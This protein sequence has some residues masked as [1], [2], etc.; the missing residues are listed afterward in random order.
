MVCFWALLSQ[1]KDR[2]KRLKK[3]QDGQPIPRSPPQTRKTVANTHAALA[4]G[5]ISAPVGAGNVE[6]SSEG[7]DQS[8]DDADQSYLVPP[9]RKPHKPAPAPP[10]EPPSS[11]DLPGGQSTRLGQLNDRMLAQG[12]RRTR[13]T[14]ATAMLNS[15]TFT[16]HNAPLPPPPPVQAQQAQQVPRRHAQQLPGPFVRVDTVHGMRGHQCRYISTEHGSCNNRQITGSTQCDAHTCTTPGCNTAKSSRQVQCVGC[17]LASLQPQPQPQPQPSNHPTG[18]PSPQTSRQRSAPTGS[19]SSQPPELQSGRPRGHGYAKAHSAVTDVLPGPDDYMKP[20]SAR[21][22]SPSPK[23]FD[24]DTQSLRAGADSRGG[25]NT[26]I[27]YTVESTGRAMSPSPR[28]SRR[29]SPRPHNIDPQKQPSPRSSPVISR[30]SS[31]S[32]ERQSRGAERWL[33][34]SKN[35]AAITKMAPQPL[36]PFDS[37]MASMARGSPPPIPD[38]DP[39]PATELLQNTEGRRSLLRAMPVGMQQPAADM[40]LPCKSP[41]CSRPTRPGERYCANCAAGPTRAAADMTLPCKSPGCSRPARPG[42]RYCTNCAVG[43]TRTRTRSTEVAPAA[44]YPGISDSAFAS[45]SYPI[46]GND[47]A[48]P[49]PGPVPGPGS[50]LAASFSFDRT[51]SDWLDSTAM[52]G[53]SSSTD[54]GTI[55][56]EAAIAYLLQKCGFGSL[57]DVKNHLSSAAPNQKSPSMSRRLAREEPKF[58]AKPVV[59]GVTTWDTTLAPLTQYDEVPQIIPESVCSFIAAVTTLK[60]V[61]LKQSP[62][63]FS[64]ALAIRTGVQAFRSCKK[65]VSPDDALLCDVTQVLEFV[66]PEMGYPKSHASSVVFTETVV[67]LLPPPGMSV[68]GYIRSLGPNAHP[69]V[70]VRGV[71]RR[72]HH[73]WPLLPYFSL[74]GAPL[75]GVVGCCWCCWCCWCCL[76]FSFGG[77]LWTRLPCMLCLGPHVRRMLIGVP[78]LRL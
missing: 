7:S 37:S 47:A 17:D 76:F 63:P 71:R 6:S 42:E 68:G 49:G 5:L 48:G 16:F 14:G 30:R 73:F 23:V 72:R 46:Y 77:F 35:A 69:R 1:D 78:A 74:Y 34:V 43:H 61:W 8:S 50:S 56:D 15:S 36:P 53:G 10:S 25:S 60:L 21:S 38:N 12:H 31:P 20:P 2:K 45:A 54:H 55:D 13:S 62:D 19:A 67:G 22:P 57:A 40:T 11:A 59:T 32:C 58:A 52:L 65:I 29:L 41:G 18:Y 9:T 4:K 27:S 24:P 33:Q 26:G 66:A 70:G 64:W 3:G 39:P 75:L 28:G 51:P 44:G